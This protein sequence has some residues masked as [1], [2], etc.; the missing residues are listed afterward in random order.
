MDRE[1]WQ[2]TIHRVTKSW[3]NWRDLACMHG[4]FNIRKS[5]YCP[6]LRIKVKPVR[7]CQLM[8][9]KYLTKLNILIWFFFKVQQTR[10][11]RKWS[12]H[13]TGQVGKTHSWDH[14]LVK[15]WKF[16]SKIRN[17]CACFQGIQPIFYSNYKWNL[18]FKNCESLYCTPEAYIIL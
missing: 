17:K 1:D 2:G 9:K 10:N 15:D 18:T 11:R 16:L 13:N 4:W 3:H 7:A 6:T 14:T 5:V 8:Q 12:Q